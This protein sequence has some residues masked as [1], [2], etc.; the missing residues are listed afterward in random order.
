MV[1][2]LI[3]LAAEGGSMPALVVM[4]PA[5]IHSAIF[6]VGVNA[7]SRQSPHQRCY[8]EASV[9]HTL[10]DDL[11]GI[12]SGGRHWV[13]KGEAKDIGCPECRS[14]KSTDSDLESLSM[15]CTTVMRANEYRFAVSSEVVHHSTISVKTDPG[16]SAVNPTRV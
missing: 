9:A 14:N 16:V 2:R 6:N 15:T 1:T 5:T 11:P 7:A 3:P 10:V 12:S 13:M 4:K 8:L